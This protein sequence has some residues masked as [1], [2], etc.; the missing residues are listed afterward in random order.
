MIAGLVLS[1]IFQPEPGIPEPEVSIQSKQ[2]IDHIG[3]AAEVCGLV[4]NVRFIPNINGNPTF[5]NF[6][7]PDPN[8]TFTAVIWS[9]NRSKWNPLPEK[10][11]PD[12]EICITGRIESHQGTPQIE[13]IHRDQISFN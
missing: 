3:K 8:Q 6:D 9:E 1:R 5:I 7:Q 11:Y 13:V 10:I 12:K 2:A 4:A